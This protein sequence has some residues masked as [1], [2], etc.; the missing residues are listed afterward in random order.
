M[1]HHLLN[2]PLLLQ[3]SQRLPRQAPINLEPV[4]ENGNS[5][6]SVGLHFLVEFVA[7]RFVKDDGVVG[8]VLYCFAAKIC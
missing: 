7:G 5:N 8:F 3:L 4:H 6:E 1:P 2:H